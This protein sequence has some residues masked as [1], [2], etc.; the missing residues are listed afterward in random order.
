MRRDLKNVCGTCNFTL[1]TF[2]LGACVFMLTESEL[3]IQQSIAAWLE[4]NDFQSHYSV[5]VSLME[6]RDC[7]GIGD[8]A[9]LWTMAEIVAAANRDEPGKLNKELREKIDGVTFPQPIPHLLIA[10]LHRA[11][12]FSE[13]R[14]LMAKSGHTLDSLVER[15]RTPVRDIA[16]PEHP[17]P[18]E[19]MGYFRERQPAPPEWTLSRTAKT[20]YLKYASS[21]LSHEDW[22]LAEAAAGS[23][24]YG[25]PNGI[26]DLMKRI[27]ALY[28]KTVIPIMLK[29]SS[30]SVRAAIV[31]PGAN[32]ESVWSLLHDPDSL[33]RA[34]AVNAITRDLAKNPYTGDPIQLA[35]RINREAHQVGDVNYADQLNYLYLLAVRFK[36]YLRY[37]YPARNMP[38]PHGMRIAFSILYFVIS[39]VALYFFDRAAIQIGMTE[40][41]RMVLGGIVGFCLLGFIWKQWCREYGKEKK[42][43]EAS[44]RYWPGAPQFCKMLEGQSGL[45]DNDYFAAVVIFGTSEGL[46]SYVIDDNRRV[47]SHIT[48]D[49]QNRKKGFNQSQI[50]AWQGL[51]HQFHLYR[52]YMLQM[53]H[54]GLPRQDYVIINAFYYR[55]GGLRPLIMTIEEKIEGESLAHGIFREALPELLQGPASYKK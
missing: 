51:K 28:G 13:F 29:S 45:A 30:P 49:G 2:Y 42:M 11:G 38:V 1:I 31:W 50:Q 52:N 7:T 8:L 4:A 40:P 25:Y 17:S 24:G 43:L 15:L 37:I 39:A 19:A 23:V 35:A 54:C 14:E 10:E 44:G 6:L 36:H 47:I 46:E 20:E 12:K 5:L 26:Y 48:P 18:D 22:D 16:E 32:R 34:L 9:V 33:V 53:R 3:L 55:S 21:L 41:T 27:L